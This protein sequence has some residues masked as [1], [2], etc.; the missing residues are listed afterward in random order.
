MR[1]LLLLVLMTTCLHADEWWAWSNLE[2]W[3]NQQ[4]R[5]SLFL[6]NRADVDDGSYVQIASPRVKHALLPW[7]E[8]GIGLSLLSIENTR[9]GD[10]LM[11]FRPE[12]ELNPH[13][14]LTKHPALERRHRRDLLWNDAQTFRPHRNRQP[15][16][17][18]LTLP[19]PLGHLTRL[20]LLKPSLPDPPRAPAAR[21]ARPR[22]APPARL[23]RGSPGC[24]V[25]LC[26][27]AV[28]WRSVHLGRMRR[29]R[30]HGRIAAL[31][32]CRERRVLVP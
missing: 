10:R 15:R 12:L 3:R 17:L 28:G 6:G 14:N 26:A 2:F 16:Q 13:F 1:F 30:G 19:R 9:T 5:A 32:R 25:D 8:G 27:R 7:L 29:G 18:A 21:R 22:R 11:Q 31:A 20:L 23:P 24:A 4:T